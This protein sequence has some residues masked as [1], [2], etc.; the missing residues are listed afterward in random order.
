M[1]LTRIGITLLLIAAWLV[2]G[3]LPLL[4]YMAKNA[5]NVP[6][7]A[8][9]FG[10]SAALDGDTT[11]I[12]APGTDYAYLFSRNQGG[13]NVWGVVKSFSWG[14]WFDSSLSVSGDIAVVGAPVDG[15]IHIFYRNQ[16]GTNN[17]GRI[18]MISGPYL[19]GGFGHAVAISG[20]TIVVGAYEAIVGSTRQGAAYIYQRDQGGTGSWGL[21][22]QIVATDGAL[23]DWF[24]NSVSINGDTVVVGASDADVNGKVDQGA[25]YVF[26]RPQGGTNNWGQVKKVIAADGASRDFFGEEV[27]IDGNMIV[28]GAWAAEV[29]GKTDQGAAYVFYRDYGGVSNWGQIRKLVAS[30]GA[31]REHFGQVSIDGDTIVVGANEATIGANQAQGAA[32]VFYR[33]QG[34]ADNWGQVR[35]VMALDGKTYDDFGEAQVSGNT[36]VVGAFGAEAAYV[37]YRDQGGT[38]NWGQVKKLVAAIPALQVAGRVTNTRHQSVFNTSI[39]AQPPALNIAQSDGSGTYTLFIGTSGVYTLTASR[40]GF[41][42]L[43]PRYDV[44]VSSNLSGIDFV[45]PPVDDVVVNGGWETGDLSGW[46]VGAGL[47]TTVEMTSAHTGHY[48]LRLDSSGIGD[49]NFEPSITQSVVISAGWARPT[50]SWLYQVA[51]ASPGDAFLV[52]ASAENT[53]I[54]ATLPLTTGAWLHEWLDL[55]TFSALTVTLQFGFQTQ[56]A[57]QQILLDEVSVGDSAVGVYP[58][59]LPLIRRSS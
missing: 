37:F 1:K 17:W 48:G 15:V 5:V 56:A 31:A 29:N 50:L 22:K 14:D 54:T 39:S 36:L 35:K 16:G 30:D 53:T 21:V 49:L 42:T 23:D 34:G 11:L 26:F 4:A 6:T 32:Y 57:G 45:L 43:P 55:S 20:D 18:R 13:A 58:V 40:I 27:S 28:V 8:P 52:I 25:A 24:G 47:T 46:S 10:M 19:S 51:Q 3:A 9:G 7:V 33:N 38:N 59:Y 44:N 41:E 2:N 12:G